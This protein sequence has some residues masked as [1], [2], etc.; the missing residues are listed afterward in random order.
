MQGERSGIAQQFPLAGVDAGK[1]EGEAGP[2]GQNK[3]FAP[4]PSGKRLGRPGW[5]EIVI[6]VQKKWGFHV[7]QMNAAAG[8]VKVSDLVYAMKHRILVLEY[9]IKRYQLAGVR[10][11]DVGYMGARSER[12]RLV[13]TVDTVMRY[14]EI[15]HASSGV[16]GRQ[17]GF[18]L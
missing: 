9:T 15:C 8:S 18:E 2:P 5:T 16:E 12:Q 3:C 17:S 7:K 6:P 13:A 1:G 10:L 11:D 14:A 4:L